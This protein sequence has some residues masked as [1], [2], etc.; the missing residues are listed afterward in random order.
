MAESYFIGTHFQLQR[1]R[2]SIVLLTALAVSSASAQQEPPQGMTSMAVIPSSLAHML[3]YVSLTWYFI[4]WS[5]CLLGLGLARQFAHSESPRSPLSP[6]RSSSILTN[7]SENSSSLDSLIR[8]Q[9]QH[10]NEHAE[11]VPGVS[12]LRPLSGLDCN[13]YSNLSS[14]FT[15]DYPTSRFEVV[16]SIRDT[17]FSESQKVLNIARMVVAAHP[18]VDARI[19][20][21]DQ[22]AGVNPKINNLVR[23]YAASKYDILWVVDSQVWSPSGALARA[24]DDLCTDAAS[25]PRPSPTWLPRKTHGQRVGLVH[26]VPFAVLPSTSW[27]SRI[28]RVFLSTTHAKMYLALNALS[29]DSCVMGKSN[30]YR[31]SDLACVPDSFFNVSHNGSQG[32]EGAIGSFAFSQQSHTAS[33]INMSG[34][35]SPSMPSTSNDATHT[36]SGDQDLS[37]DQVKTLSR[38]FARFSIYLAEDNMLAQ[39]LWDPP[40]NLSHTLSSSDLAYTSVGDIRTLAD[41]TR[42]RMRWIRVR[43]YMVLA[44]T[45][46]EPLTESVLSS[47]VGWFALSTLIFPALLSSSQPLPL[48]YALLFFSFHFGAWFV[49]DYTMFQRLSVAHEFLS[50]NPGVDNADKLGMIEFAAAWVMREALAL[51]IWAWAILGSTVSWRNQTY[52]ILRGGRAAVAA[53]SPSKLGPRRAKSRNVHHDDDLDP[54]LHSDH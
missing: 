35:A 52:C 25:R 12:I 33:H 28:E 17:S 20:L 34:S 31:K 9:Q 26:H 16:L 53:S 40:L 36:R 19:I 3:A 50:C 42:R 13:L 30:M 11:S 45:L 39:S 8:R 32:E 41:Y 51:P 18:H 38:P 6:P 5:V 37:N 43:K 48:W 2:C 27:G 44:P 49:V 4:I 23:S 54:L 24:V 14:S 1:L 15:Q 46:L 7:E 10:S 21:G 47:F 22:F 29:I